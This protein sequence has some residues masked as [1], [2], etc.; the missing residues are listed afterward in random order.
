MI[1]R[2]IIVPLAAALFAIFGFATASAQSHAPGET[3]MAA[4]PV[5][6]KAGGEVNIIMPDLTNTKIKAEFLGGQSGHNLLMIGIVISVLGMGFGMWI[7][8]R[9]KGMPVHRSM[10]DISELIYATCKAYLFRQGK[11]LMLL[12]AF[13][14]IAMVAYFKLLV[15]VSWADMAIILL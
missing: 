8:M 11:F 5:A 12:W 10:L 13:I 4:A 7:Y 3:K 9:L 2:P 1:K 15:E 6:H 14:A